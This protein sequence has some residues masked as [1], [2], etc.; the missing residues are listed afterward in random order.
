MCVSFVSGQFLF[1]KTGWEKQMDLLGTLPVSQ[2][3]IPSG[4]GGKETLHRGSTFQPRN[5][6][7]MPKA[8]HP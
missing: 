2:Y 4:A 8:S 7:M 5:Q 6:D 3:L 1:R